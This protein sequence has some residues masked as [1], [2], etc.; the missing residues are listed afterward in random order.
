MGR[1]IWGS[2]VFLQKDVPKEWHY[3]GNTRL[4]DLFL[5]SD[6]G[7]EVYYEP[8]NWRPK[9]FPIWGNHGYNNTLPSMK[10]LFIANG[11]SFKTS[12][13][14]PK[15]F[16]NVDLFP[17]ML[18]LLQ[19]PISAYPSNGSFERVSDMLDKHL[20]LTDND[21]IRAHSIGDDD[22]SGMLG[23]VFYGK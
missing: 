2:K 20:Y 10:P 7:T 9:G 3:N 13:V 6:D 11:R 16:E 17:L 19:I 14:Y 1:R 18:H 22:D 15:T 4:L 12:F 5:L 23:K 21:Y 8:P